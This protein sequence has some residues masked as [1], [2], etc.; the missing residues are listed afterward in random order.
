[1]TYFHPFTDNYEADRHN[2]SSDDVL[3]INCEHENDTISAE[4]ALDITSISETGFEQVKDIADTTSI[5]ET[6]FQPDK[7]DTSE[8]KYLLLTSKS[9]IDHADEHL[10]LDVD[11]PKI[12]PKIETNGIA[13]T[14]LYLDCANEL[15]ERKSL[16]ESSQVVHPLLLTCVGNSR[17]QISLSSLVEEVNIAI[18][19]LTSYS[20]N[21]E[22][23]L[24]LDN[25]CAMLERDMN[26]NNRLMNGIWN[27]G[28]RHGFSCDEVEKVVHEVENMVLGGLI[29]EI[30][31]N[32]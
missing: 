21:S 15:A 30:I 19:N 13:N 3:M 17:L 20:E 1:V 22:T 24:I 31:V 28:W 7:V 25:V 10:N 26:C 11:Y 27:C 9:F 2:S 4:E 29:E 8:L 14:K 18:E 16:Q 6:D 12:I 32:L 5:S 23:K